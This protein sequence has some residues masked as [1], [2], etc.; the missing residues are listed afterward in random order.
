[1]RYID[2]ILKARIEKANQTLYENANPAM[3]A[4][5]SRHSTPLTE[6][7]FL[8]RTKI[9]N[10]T[11][12]SRVSIAARRPDVN[13]Q[14]DRIYVAFC[15]NGVGKVA[16]ADQTAAMSNHVWINIETIPDAI[17][18]AVTFDGTMV[19]NLRNRIEF[20]TTDS[21]PWVFWIDSAGSLYGK[22]IG[23]DITTITLA[24]VNASAVTAIRGIQLDV[25]DDDQGLL[26]FFI[27]DGSIYY[28]QGRAGIWENALPL[29]FGPA[30][31]WADISVSRTWDY[32]I[33]LQAKASDGNVYE[34]FTQYEG[35]AKQNVERLEIRDITAV[36]E[37]IEVTYIDTKEEDERIEINNISGSGQIIYGLSPVPVS[38]VNVNDGTGEWG[39]YIDLEFD[40]PVMGIIGSASQFVIKDG[41]NL[42]YDGQTIEYIGLDN[43]KV[44]I[45]YINFNAAY[46]TTCTINYTPGTVQ[47]PAAAL[48]AFSFSFTPTKLVPPVPA[49]PLNVNNSD[50]LTIVVEFDGNITS[51]DWV[52]VKAAFSVT[53]SE[54]DYVPGG[55]LSAKTYTIN[56][57]GYA[58]GTGTN[59]K[60]IAIALT[61][62]G[63]LK[64]PQGNVSVA[65]NQTTGNLLSVGGAIV[66]FN[67]ALTPV[68]LT[69]IYAGAN[70]IEKVQI[71][72]VTGTGALVSITYRDAKEEEKI[73][74][75]D[76]TALGKLTHINDL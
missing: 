41:N 18:I 25:A 55:T 53:G 31:T 38:C 75:S 68:G 54:Y 46:G 12:V 33:V 34:S 60:R 6:Q 37:P 32:R 40:Y 17:D 56:A 76:V 10:Y 39:K 51:A 49:V 73:Q 42:S 74:I 19:K 35:I 1:M 62:A 50:A 43:K 48:S 15:D 61:A 52:A 45:G 27:L 72:N 57:I 20:K 65:Y 23:E 44:R 8:E 9:G 14:A 22:L 5:I 13:R 30:V 11:N 71:T 28:R 58:D 21:T 64:A 47:G 24:N 29:N 59:K 67:L 16:Y 7:T 3:V 66:S 36:G 2:P 26:V 69:P 4:W 70:D 63:R